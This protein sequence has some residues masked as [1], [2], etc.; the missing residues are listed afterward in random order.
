MVSC[1]LSEVRREILMEMDDPVFKLRL[2][3]D[4]C[5]MASEERRVLQI[6][7]DPSLLHHRSMCHKIRTLS[8]LW[9]GLRSGGG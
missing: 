6:E 4:I 9:F 1:V 8:N 5:C 7:E 3:F 2:K